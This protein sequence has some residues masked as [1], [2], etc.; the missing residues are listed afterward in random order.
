MK[1]LG[2]NRDLLD[3]PLLKNT[4]S[5]KEIVYDWEWVEIKEIKVL[6]PKDKR[7]NIPTIFF[8]I[9]ENRKVPHYILGDE[10]C[11]VVEGGTHI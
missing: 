2:E 4:A 9:Y 10:P 7:K 1:K 11:N 6:L 3:K 5:I 8:E